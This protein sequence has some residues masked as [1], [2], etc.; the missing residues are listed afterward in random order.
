MK[1]SRFRAGALACVAVALSGCTLFFGAAHLDTGACA[2]R[3][4]REGLRMV[5]LVYHGEFASSCVCEMPRGSSSSS[6]S[7]SSEGAAIA[8]AARP[9]WRN[10]PV[11]LP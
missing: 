7:S 11:V 4:R 9:V 3:C 1:K 6:S 5:A 8:A 2:T 10:L